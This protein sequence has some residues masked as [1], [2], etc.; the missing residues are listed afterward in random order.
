MTRNDAACLG[1]F[2][3]GFSWLTLRANTL[4]NVE[5]LSAIALASVE[6]IDLIGSALHSAN[7]LVH[8]VELT[9]RALG[10]EVV[11]KVVSGLTD[12]PVQDPV[13]VLG[14]D[15]SAH[16]IASLSAD[17]LISRNA[18]AALALLV[19]DLS[20]RVALAADA[21]D[22]VESGEAA[23]GSDGWIP[24]LVCLTLSAAD[25]IDSVVGLSGGANST[26]VSDQVVSF[27]ADA[28]SI[29]INL[30]GVASRGAKSEVLDEA[31]I[32]R[33]SLGQL[34]IL[35]VGGA[36]ITGSIAHFEVLREADALALTDI[37]NSIRVAG[38]SADAETLVIY[39]IPVALPADS[40]DWVVASFAAALAI[41]EDLIDSAS[42][43]AEA[44]S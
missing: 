29:L 1:V 25:S 16:A 38:H 15:R 37:V 3:V 26:G 19:V 43:G 21:I 27:L 13:F 12:A 32:A 20:L 33:A 40:L 22:Q 9:F 39:F 30:V 6:V 11:N 41:Q 4:D 44:T 36:D 31:S 42:D 8:V 28:L 23:A 35:R 7:H 10:A 5:A 17:F 18:I 34:I 14:T 2:V 24:N